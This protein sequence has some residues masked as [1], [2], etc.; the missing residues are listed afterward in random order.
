MLDIAEEES[1]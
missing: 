1:D